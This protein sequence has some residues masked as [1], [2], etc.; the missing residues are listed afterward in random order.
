[1]LGNSPNLHDSYL[2]LELPQGAPLNDAKVAYRDLVRIWHP[3]RFQ[4]DDRLRRRC[5]EKVKQLNA[6]YQTL[7]AA[8]G[9][10]GPVT[11]A[12]AA[13]AP[14]APTS[15]G[16]ALEPQLHRGKWGYADRSGSF[17]ISPVYDTASA[18][19]E[20]LAAVSQGGACGYVSEDGVLAIEL[21]FTVA[22]RFCE[23]LAMVKFGRCGY[24]NRQG[25]WAVRPRFDAGLE[26]CSGVAPVKLDGKWGI[27]DAYG[28]WLVLPRFD[29][30]NAFESG[31]ALAREGARSFAVY[32]SG[33]IRP[34]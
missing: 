15:Y 10:Q 32:P 8:L 13:P 27:I 11:S 14:A 18:F 12:A 33:D 2:V 26:F 1:M 19:S 22:R 30:M 24:I 25:E 17:R 29:D 3:D 5:E 23:G 31:R 6:A 16:A 9:R 20:G 7:E 4:T 34:L 21:R 28:K